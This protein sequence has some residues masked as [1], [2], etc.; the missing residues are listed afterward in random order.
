MAQR[1]FLTAFFTALLCVMH[2]ASA[3]ASTSSKVVFGGVP[4]GSCNLTTY[5]GCTI[6]LATFTNTTGAP[7][8]YDTTAIQTGVDYALGPDGGTCDFSA[9]APGSSCS[10]KVTVAPNH[11]GLDRGAISLRQGTQV[12]LVDQMLAAGV[13]ARPKGG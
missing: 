8:F 3:S 11:V 9:L 10:I 6:K 13:P 4:I 7:L 12:V 2:V 5:E 1:V